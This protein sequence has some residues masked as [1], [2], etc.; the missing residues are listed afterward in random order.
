MKEGMKEGIQ[1]SQ[2]Q[3]VLNMINNN[4]SYN[5]ISKATGIDESKI[6]DYIL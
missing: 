4:F 2:K 3:I 1:R 5:D 6:K